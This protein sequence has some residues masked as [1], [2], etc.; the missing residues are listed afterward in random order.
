MVYPTSSRLSNSSFYRADSELHFDA[1]RSENIKKAVES[2]VSTAV[3]TVKQHM[4]SVQ[5]L[6]LQ[7]AWPGLFWVH[8]NKNGWLNKLV[9][10]AACA[11]QV[12][13][14]FDFNHFVSTMNSP[15]HINKWLC[16]PF[17]DLTI[18]GPNKNIQEIPGWNILWMCCPGQR[19]SREPD[20]GHSGYCC[21]CLGGVDKVIPQTEKQCK[22]AKG[23]GQGI[24][25]QETKEVGVLFGA[26]AGFK[27][28]SKRQPGPKTLQTSL[29]CNLDRSASTCPPKYVAVKCLHGVGKWERTQRSKLRTPQPIFGKFLYT[30]ETVC[31]TMALYLHTWNRVPILNRG[32]SHHGNLKL[33]G[34][35][36]RM[37]K[38]G[39]SVVMVSGA[40]LT[41]PAEY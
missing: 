7:K 41:H 36:T 6:D 21:E 32:C 40:V 29:I 10:H 22:W 37:T 13:G 5:K 26:G 2:E 27:F 3:D 39:E 35:Q 16:I 25:V 1:P 23:K 31:Q 8:S 24:D 19:R 18:I 17:L 11:G 34:V 15:Y 38:K 9:L 12:R 14:D 28:P 30:R 20:F 4:L 33:A